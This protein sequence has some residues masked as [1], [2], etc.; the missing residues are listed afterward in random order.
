MLRKAKRRGLLLLS[1]LPFLSFLS[2]FFLLF[3]SFSPFFSSKIPVFKLHSQP[4]MN[5]FK[6]S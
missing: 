1:L 2:L 5:T 3:P 4:T 6:R